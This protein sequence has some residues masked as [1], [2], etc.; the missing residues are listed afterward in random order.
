MTGT[1]NTD[2]L[3]RA[4]RLY[5]RART[6]PESVVDDLDAVVS[7]LRYGLDESVDSA[8]VAARVQVTAA[9]TL[10]Q[11][12]SVS[13]PI[14]ELLDY[15]RELFGA[16]R[17]RQTKLDTAAR[18]ERMT[19]IVRLLETAQR[20]TLRSLRA[21]WA[22]PTDANWKRFLD[23]YPRFVAS[24]T[25]PVLERLY[26]VHVEGIL[27]RYEA[28][29]I[30]HL[31]DL[32][33]PLT[34][35][36]PPVRQQAI[37]V[38]TALAT[39]D[40]TE[41]A[42]YVSDVM[43]LLNGGRTALEERAI[44]LCFELATDAPELV[45]P[46]A[47]ALTDTLSSGTRA[48]RF[49][50]LQAVTSHPQI[51]DARTQDVRA[52]VLRAIDA[53]DPETRELAASTLQECPALIPSET[54]AIEPL[55]DHMSMDAEGFTRAAHQILREI[56]K[57]RPER[58]APHLET[59]LDPDLS[60]R[61]VRQMHVTLLGYALAKSKP[62][63]LLPHIDTF[64]SIALAREDGTGDI[65][66]TIDDW[67]RQFGEAAAISQN[68]TSRL[69]T[70]Q[71]KRAFDRSYRRVAQRSDFE[72]D[73]DSPEIHRRSAIGILS[74]LTRSAPTS[75]A[76]KPAVQA[77]STALL[78][79]EDTIR[80][81]AIVGLDSV[82]SADQSAV[83]EFIP[84]YLRAVRRYT[85]EN[86]PEIRR[87]V[88]MILAQSCEGA[89]DTDDVDVFSR[90]TLEQILE[91]PVSLE[92][93]DAQLRPIDYQ[94]IAHTIKNATRT[95]L[96]NHAS[97]DSIDLDADRST[98]EQAADSLG[99]T[100]SGRGDRPT[101][102]LDEHAFSLAA[103]P[104]RYTTHALFRVLQSWASV[105]PQSVV[106]HVR[107]VLDVI[108]RLPDEDAPRTDAVT[109]A[110]EET[111]GET[112]LLATEDAPKA[113]N[114][115]ANTLIA[116]IPE[117][118]EAGL[119]LV[120]TVAESAPAAL[121]PHVD[122]LKSMATDADTPG[123]DHLYGALRSIAHAYPDQTTDLATVFVDGLYR[124]DVVAE[125]SSEA[126]T[127]LAAVAPDGLGPHGSSI[128]ATLRTDASAATL[129]NASYTLRL[130]AEADPALTDDVASTIRA[131]RPVTAPQE[132]RLTDATAED[133]AA[134]TAIVDAT[135]PSTDLIREQLDACLRIHDQS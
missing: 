120:E 118:V 10:R 76:V 54:I 44:T 6:D 28:P 135:D 78:V 111:L 61:G 4:E 13:T 67:T 112:T 98:T 109:E 2:R 69:E 35:E 100:G 56:A 83:T 3:S 127:T 18:A 16:L 33:Q 43:P 7:D 70:L 71:A 58:V 57:D 79:D 106:P 12:T 91:L 116:T 64:V 108:A 46:Y 32:T 114:A 113:T 96:E 88:L 50:A 84:L 126:L 73:A 105:N 45:T 29:V 133:T 87:R 80:N 1:A 82:L 22:N 125:I 110:Y 26:L 102:L 117:T 34:A 30:E 42:D 115:I 94:L 129:L 81:R 24:G 51:T 41:A 38:L 15:Q 77:V 90:R 68:V 9:D 8:L 85:A 74:I 122:A 119:A 131:Q 27:Q 86:E 95:V 132:P 93:E 14:E 121:L 37:D 128:A 101:G 60:D 123:A 63:V 11:L 99:T 59:L 72:L 31:G 134:A 75:E 53:S 130:L 65:A 89:Y 48:V 19:G 49:S 92:R 62:A 52:E 5:R 104:R 17:A 25:T 97:S 36:E 55:I 21:I 103:A 124:S 66:A 39:I 20:K 23:L 47:Q 107:A 40:P